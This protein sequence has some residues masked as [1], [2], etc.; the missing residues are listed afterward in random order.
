MLETHGLGQTVG[1]NHEEGRTVL[2]GRPLP[3][4]AG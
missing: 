4:L 1:V 2:E 3:L